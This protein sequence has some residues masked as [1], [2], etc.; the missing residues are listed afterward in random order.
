MCNNNRKLTVY[1]SYSLTASW[2]PNSTTCSWLIARLSK[3]SS[4]LSCD[5]VLAMIFRSAIRTKSPRLATRVEMCS[6]FSLVS[7]APYRD[8]VY[9][10]SLFLLSSL[11]HKVSSTSIKAIVS[12]LTCVSVSCRLVT[13]LSLSSVRMRCSVAL[14]SLSF[15]S[16]K[17]PG[18]FSSGDGGALWSSN[19]STGML[20]NTHS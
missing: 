6:C 18:S 14:R 15:L 19:C 9:L 5:S 8:N 17:K 7:S 10:S 3:S 16:I 4:S 11:S 1:V 13:I 2:K 20:T 12:M